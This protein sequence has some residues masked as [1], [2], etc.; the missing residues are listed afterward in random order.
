MP[1]ISEIDRA[2]MITSLATAIGAEEANVLATALN[3]DGQLATRDELRVMEMALRTDLADARQDLGRRIDENST[4]I[5]SLKSEIGALRTEFQTDLKTEIG[6]L[7][8]EVGDLR[9]EMQGEFAAVRAELRSEMQGEFASVRAELR[10]EIGGLRS[11]M[12]AGFA[13]VA[14]EFVGV[15]AETAALRADFVVFQ[16]E[17]RSEFA[18][19]RSEL[20]GE[21]VAMKDE[22]KDGFSR[23]MQRQTKQLFVG[24]IGILATLVSLVTGVL[25]LTGRL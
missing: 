13:S 10:S 8:S 12:Q 18:L 20:R 15:R 11:E 22:L 24:M 6:S 2:R 23:D 25:G 19:V 1:S 3:L 7:R 4:Q 17:T 21:M 14:A 16:A 5:Q 9:S